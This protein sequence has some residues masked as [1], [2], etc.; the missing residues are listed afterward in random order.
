MIFGIGTD[1]VETARI[2]QS[3]EKNEKFAPRILTPFEIS[4][5]NASKCPEAYL[6]KRFAAKEALVKAIGTGIGNG[7]SW[8]MCEVN[9]TESGQPFF[10]VTGAINDLFQLNNLNCF[11]SISDEQTYACAMVV[12]ERK[13]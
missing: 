9:N 13:I 2:K 6:A 1:I 3:L 12:L 10:V 11:L 4:Q 8:Q 7:I 5:F